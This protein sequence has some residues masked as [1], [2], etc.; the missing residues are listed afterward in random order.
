MTA[1][2]DNNLAV[3]LI[4]QHLKGGGG[5]ASIGGGG[6]SISWLVGYTPTITYGL[7][8]L[9]LKH[10]ECHPKHNVNDDL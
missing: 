2:R 8:T 1:S 3:P 7:R 6:A 5:G 10:H 9:F 4:K